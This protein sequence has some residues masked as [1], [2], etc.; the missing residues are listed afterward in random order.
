M[1]LLKRA[2]LAIYQKGLGWPCA[3]S[4]CPQK[5]IITFQKFFLFSV[6]IF[7][8]YQYLKN[9]EGKVRKCFLLG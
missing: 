9:M 1:Q 2:I 6:S 5:V 7:G 8:F 4:T 3:V